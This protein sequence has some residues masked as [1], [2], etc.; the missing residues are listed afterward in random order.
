MAS[1]TFTRAVPVEDQYDILVAGGGPAGGAPPRVA[2]RAG[3]PGP[4]APRPPARPAAA[5][6]RVGA[7]PPPH[8]ARPGV[9]RRDGRCGAGRGLWGALQSRGP[10]LAVPAGNGVL[11][12]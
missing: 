1:H 5:A 10:R 6:A 9:H 11:D 8:V 4:A 2:A 3:P 7:R 12:L